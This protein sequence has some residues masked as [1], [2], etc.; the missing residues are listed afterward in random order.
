MLLDWHDPRSSHTLSPEQSATVI[1]I[2]HRSIAFALGS[3]C[4]SGACGGTFVSPAN[5]GA[6]DAANGSGDANG[7]R[8]ES[9]ETSGSAPRSQKIGVAV[10]AFTDLPRMPSTEE[11]SSTYFDAD[12][13]VLYAIQDKT[14]SI[15]ALSGSADY[16]SWTPQKSIALSD[17]PGPGWDGEGLTFVDGKFYAVTM[18]TA[19]LVETFDPNGAFLGTVAIPAVYTQHRTGNKGLESLTASPDGKYLFTVNEQALSVDGD[20]PTKTRGTTARVLRRELSA[21]RDVEVAYRTDPLGPGTGGDMGIAELAALSGDRL[22]VLERGYQ[23][24]YGNT[25]R[26]YEVSLAGAKD[27]KSATSLGDETPVLQKTLVVDLVTL[28]SA[29]FQTPGRQKNPLLDNYECMSLGPT[30]EDGRRLLFLTSDDN[31]SKKQVPRVLVLA[32]T[33]L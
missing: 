22:L 23:S 20:A 13:R 19:P 9:G 29:G 33:G 24:D 31:G 25:V 15:T 2:F 7:K 17:R 32:V 4:A 5:D 27:V 16:K 12:A 1:N 30:L 8:G 21:D 11:L 3:L 28:P 10:Y 26:I 18:E 14:P 6:V